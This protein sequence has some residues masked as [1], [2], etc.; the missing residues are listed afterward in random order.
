MD[1]AQGQKKKKKKQ[2]HIGGFFRLTQNSFLE[3]AQPPAKNQSIAS[4][5]LDPVKEPLSQ[6]VGQD[7]SEQGKAG[8]TGA[9]IVNPMALLTHI[10]VDRAVLGL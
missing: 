5:V 10:R 2:T 4:V 7:Q 9:H 3:E 1:D 8:P 6:L